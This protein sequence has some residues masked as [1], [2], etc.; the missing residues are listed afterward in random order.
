MPLSM[1]ESMQLDEVLEH[2]NVPSYVI[3]TAGVVR[4][5]NEAGRKLV[6]DVRGRQFTSVVAPEET[7]RARELFARKVVGASKVTDAGV[8]LLD[9]DGKRISVEISSV[10]LRDGQHVVG[11]FGQVSEVV[12]EPHE[13]PDLDLTPRQAE[14]LDLLERGRTTTQI[15]QELHLSIETVRNHIRGILRATGTHSRLEAVAIANGMH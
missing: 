10:P 9:L 14:V 3:D 13:H 8:V 4:W 12:E 1:L 15:A 2:V 6:G 7:L 11:V 5:V